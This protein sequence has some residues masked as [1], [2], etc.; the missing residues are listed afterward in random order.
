MDGA[1]QFDRAGREQAFGYE[2]HRCLRCCRHKR[3][4][5]NPYEVAR[6][7]RARNVTTT[8]LRAR[9]TLDGL[10]V[11]LAQVESGDCVFLG[12]EGCTVHPDRPLVCR[13]YPLGRFVSFDGTERFGQAR[14]HPETA[15]VYH[16]RGTIGDFLASQKVETFI[17][18]A[19]EY[20]AWL[21]AAMGRLSEATGIE[22]GAMLSETAA[23]ADLT[24]LDAVLAQHAAETGTPEPAD[25]EARRRLHLSI[26]Y[27]RLENEEGDPHGS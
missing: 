3:I 12:P 27:A 2:C 17:E 10:G 26:L 23:P 11:E 7:A 14:P 1:P 21:T 19:D 9:Y 22:P 5:L 6:L 18:A 16:D 8:E 24:D 20:M 4:Q 13:L 15:G 25:L